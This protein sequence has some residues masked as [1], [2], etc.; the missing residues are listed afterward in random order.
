[1]LVSGELRKKHVSSYNTFVNVKLFQNKVH[2]EEKWVSCGNFAAVLFNLLIQSL[3]K[4]NYVTKILLISQ[5]NTRT[6]TVSAFQE[7]AFPSKLKGY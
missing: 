3:S 2:L 6:R 7:P 4:V 1:M 5:D